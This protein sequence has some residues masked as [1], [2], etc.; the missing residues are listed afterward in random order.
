MDPQLGKCGLVLDG[1]WIT[2][3]DTLEYLRYVTQV[4]RVM[5]LSGNR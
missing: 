4:K 1:E 2:E 5:E 3:Q